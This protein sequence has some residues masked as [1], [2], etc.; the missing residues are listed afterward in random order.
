MITHVKLVSIPVTNQEKSLQFY[1][2][3]LGFE[4]VVDEPLVPAVMRAGLS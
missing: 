4:V 1:R 2:D 3:K